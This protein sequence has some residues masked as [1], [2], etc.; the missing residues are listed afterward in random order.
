MSYILEALKKAERERGIRR[1]PTLATVHDF[2]GIQRIR[3]AIIVFGIIVCAAAAMWF[4]RPILNTTIRPPALSP[5]N[6]EQNTP[7]NPPAAESGATLSSVPD[8]HPAEPA[9]VPRTA[10]ASDVPPAVPPRSATP[11]TPRPEPEVRMD[12][13]RA[14]AQPD[15][16]RSLMSQSA[17]VPQQGGS[18]EASPPGQAKPASLR[19]AMSK[20]TISLLVYAEAETDRKVYING[21][22]YVKGDL[23]EGR[24]LIESITQEGATLSYQGERALLR[25]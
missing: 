7:K 16:G 9:A 24:F 17:V 2:Q 13:A 23:V 6:T 18:G 14:P 1:V 5:V 11:S 8:E 10:K 4:F 22:K 19:E 12:A 15:N 25:P 21:K 3:P 20:L